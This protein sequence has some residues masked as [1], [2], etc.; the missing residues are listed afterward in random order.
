MRSDDGVAAPKRPVVGFALLPNKVR[1]Q[2]RLDAQMLWRWRPFG[3]RK[4]TQQ[5][6]CFL[7]VMVYTGPLTVKCEKEANAF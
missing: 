3:R 5:P 2:D 1:Q 7:S 4:D 6:F